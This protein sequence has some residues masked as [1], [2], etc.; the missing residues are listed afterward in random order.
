MAK[1][2]IVI[3]DHENHTAFIEDIDTKVLDE[4]YAGEEEA[5]IKDN[6]ALGENWSWDYVTEV[7]MIVAQDFDPI[8]LDDMLD[9]YL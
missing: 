6:Y 9:A 7:E 1:E 4:K 8:D 3:I 2:R 5:Y